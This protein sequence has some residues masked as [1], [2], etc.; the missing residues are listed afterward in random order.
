MVWHERKKY[1]RRVFFFEDVVV[2]TKEGRQPDESKIFTCV[3]SLRVS[4]TIDQW[5]FYTEPSLSSVI[6][7]L[8]LM[9]S[10]NTQ[11]FFFPENESSR[12]LNCAV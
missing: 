11:Y 5:P 3:R 9:H 1:L 10:C 7:S 8:H 2:F 6:L 12:M 4:D